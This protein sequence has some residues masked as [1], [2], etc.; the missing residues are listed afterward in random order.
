VQRWRRPGRVKWLPGCCATFVHPFDSDVCAI[1]SA[2]ALSAA[3]R[4]ALPLQQARNV[5]WPVGNR[6]VFNYHR[7]LV[8]PQQPPSYISTLAASTTPTSLLL[9]AHRRKKGGKGS[10]KQ[11]RALWALASLGVTQG[12]PPICRTDTPGLPGPYI[13]ITQR[14]PSPPPIFVSLPKR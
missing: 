2:L 5:M 3:R 12:H 9:V 10:E 13:I 4:R 8:I 7:S 6:E 11:D 1:L 14:T